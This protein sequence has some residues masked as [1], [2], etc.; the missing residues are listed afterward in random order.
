MGARQKLN[1]VYLCIATFVAGFIG[2]ASKSLWIFVICFGG[3]VA[4]MF[5][6]GSL[7]AN[8]RRRR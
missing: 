8:P 3:L 1:S 2:L 5:H 4:A 7:R 6:D